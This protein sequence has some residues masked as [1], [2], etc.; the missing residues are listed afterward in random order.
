M[1][2]AKTTF[3]KEKTQ[4]LLALLEQSSK[5]GFIKS[6]TIL[7]K[8][9]RYRL[10]EEEKEDLFLEFENAGIQ[11]VFPESSD[12]LFDEFNINDDIPDSQDLTDEK[13][14]NDDSFAELDPVKQYLNEINNFP[15]LSHKETLRLVRL[16]NQGDSDARKTLVNCN[17]RFAFSVALKYLFTGL[18]LLDL[19]QQANIGLMN[20]VDKYNPNRGTRFTT[21]SVFWIKQAI[22]SY[23]ETNSRLIKIPS[24][25]GS[26]L[27]RIRSV[28]DEYYNTYRRYPS[29]DEIA[30]QT[31]FTIA[32][33]KHLKTLD[34]SI[35]SIDL[36]LS[37]DSDGTLHD[38]IMDVSV[39]DPEKN[40][41]IKERIDAIDKILNKLNKRERKILT[42]RF[43]LHG[44]KRHSLEETGDELGL[45]IERVRQIESIALSKIRNMPGSNSLR[46]FIK[47]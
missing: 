12:I 29:D 3:A 15:V 45:T 32:R 36:P 13:D 8:I 16:I 14:N 17:L 35:S 28:N 4:L 26:A 46:K 2:T 9:A 40:L 25:I 37:D 11:V 31:G 21:Y 23:I 38:I 18:P 24:Y 43:G 42:L 6:D 34:Y 20:A 22:F 47:L 5:K 39:E 10:N 27:K 1:P 19:V 30:T 7:K 33:V 41:N 44:L